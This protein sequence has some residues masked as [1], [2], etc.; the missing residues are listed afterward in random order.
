MRGILRVFG[1]L[2]IDGR[3]QLALTAYCLRTFFDAYLRGPGTS[4]TTI[5]APQYPEI[6]VF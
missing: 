6:N 3:R 5:A 2:D 4:P 1:T